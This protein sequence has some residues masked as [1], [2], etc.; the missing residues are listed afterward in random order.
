VSVIETNKLTKYYGRSRGIVDVDLAVEKGEIFGFIGPNG[1]GKSTTIRALLGL[2]FPTGG[3]GSIF[4]LDAVR[5]GRRIR[6]RLGYIPGEVEYYDRM[7]VREL[8][9]YSARFYGVELD[10]RFDH[11]VRL[12]ELDLKRNLSDLSMGNKRKVSIVLSLLHRPELLIL[13]EPTNGLDPLMQAHFYEVLRR[14]NAEGVTV[15]LSSHIL[16]EV[17]K[18]CGR[19]AIIK[20]GSVVAVEDIATLRGKH[21]NRIHVEFA[22][23]VPEGRLEIAG[24]VS[25]E[26]RNAGYRILYSG[27]INSLLTMLNRWKIRALTIEEPSLEEVFMHYYQS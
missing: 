23:E 21:L 20:E 2:I 18:V 10:G 12:F 13:D 4:G 5:N 24:T 6:R 16:G 7:S 1:A 19:V 9:E 11:L 22:E 3:T 8:M 27:D 17:Q 14:E 26:K 25:V 15:F